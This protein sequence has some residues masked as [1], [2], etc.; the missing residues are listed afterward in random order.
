VHSSVIIE[1][2][3]RSKTQIDTI[4][5]Y[6]LPICAEGV[7]RAFVTASSPIPYYRGLSYDGRARDLLDL[8]V[9]EGSEDNSSVSLTN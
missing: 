1:C 7:A 4:T 9:V 6:D 8:E 5:L 3:N 2:G